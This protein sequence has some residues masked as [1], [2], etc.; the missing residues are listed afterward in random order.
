MNDRRNRNK[1]IKQKQLKTSARLEENVSVHSRWVRATRR[2]TL[3]QHPVL[4]FVR[5]FYPG[6][7]YDHWRHRVTR[8]QYRVAWMQHR[9]AA[10][11]RV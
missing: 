6:V 8:C 9:T 11:H 10:Q 5:H 4:C 7:N 1:N 3:Q 2:L